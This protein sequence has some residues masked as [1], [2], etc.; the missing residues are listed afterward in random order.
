M[1]SFYMVFK[2][3]ALNVDDDVFQTR[4]GANK[5]ISVSVVFESVVRKPQSFSEVILVYASHRMFRAAPH[6]SFSS[7]ELQQTPY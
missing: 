5:K 6:F 1:R 2:R 3:V 7:I 4:Y